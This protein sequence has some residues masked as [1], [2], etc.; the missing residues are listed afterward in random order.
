MGEVKY[1]LGILLH[2]LQSMPNIFSVLRGNSGRSRILLFS[3]FIALSIGFKSGLADGH[4]ITLI[5]FTFK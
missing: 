3:T 1:S 4:F 5:L 2:S